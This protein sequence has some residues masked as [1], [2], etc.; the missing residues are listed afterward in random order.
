ME[1]VLIFDFEKCVHRQITHAGTDRRCHGILE[2]YRHAPHN[3]KSGFAFGLAPA[4]ASGKP[5]SIHFLRGGQ[6]EATTYPSER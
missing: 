5:E 1:D 6:G 3:I 4:A 2:R